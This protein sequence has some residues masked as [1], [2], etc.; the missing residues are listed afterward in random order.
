LVCV[1]ELGCSNYPNYDLMRKYFFPRW[2]GPSM[3][4][5]YRNNNLSYFE[6]ARHIG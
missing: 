4:I 6:A 1:N 3:L 5:I 2:I